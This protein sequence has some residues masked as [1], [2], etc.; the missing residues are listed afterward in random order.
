MKH[1]FTAILLSFLLLSSCSND[2]DDKNQ[3]GVITSGTGKFTYGLYEPLKDK[4]VT[5]YYSI[6]EGDMSAMPVIFVLPGT[7][8]DADNYIRSWTHISHEHT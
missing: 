8:R 7:N 6:G 5:V 1:T 2:D 3:E 4:P